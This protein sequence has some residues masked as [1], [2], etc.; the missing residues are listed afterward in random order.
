MLKKTASPSCSFGLPGLFRS[1]CWPCLP[2]KRDESEKPNNGLLLL[3]G[4]FERPE[5][6]VDIE[7]ML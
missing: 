4:F 6:Y 3:D 5:S 7:T 1:S 2:N